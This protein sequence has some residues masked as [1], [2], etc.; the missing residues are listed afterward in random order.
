MSKYIRTITDSNVN[1]KMS[2]DKLYLTSRNGK[3]MFNVLTGELLSNPEYQF[4]DYEYII[5]RDIMN[6]ILK[7]LVFSA[8]DDE[9]RPALQGIHVFNSKGKLR[10]ESAD[11]FR[12]SILTTDIPTTDIDIIIHKETVQKLK[13]LKNYDVIMRLLSK[14]MNG[15]DIDADNR[16]IEFTGKLNGEYRA[17]IVSSLITGYKYPDV[18]KVIEYSQDF[19][20]EIV[21]ETGSLKNAMSR[22]LLADSF[23]LGIKQL[24]DNTI[25][26]V[27]NTTEE[28]AFIEEVP[29][30][31]LKNE[32]NNKFSIGVNKGFLNDLVSKID[33]DKLTVKLNNAD[34]PMKIY[35]EELEN[36]LHIIMPMIYH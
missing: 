13:H 23:Y 5:S 9:A 12:A 27:V 31:S 22:L 36:Y 34:V 15:E 17:R 1:I 6:N 24:D 32:K 33:V 8:S 14:R 2:N 19:P 4:E 10:F 11:G 21:M 30:V 28:G 29:C 18:D 7:L 3:A 20:V 25:E 16:Y 35:S 26:M